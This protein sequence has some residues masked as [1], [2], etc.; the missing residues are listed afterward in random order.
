MTISLLTNK[1]CSLSLASGKV[2]FG[3]KKTFFEIKFV[4]VGGNLNC[5]SW[6]KSNLGNVTTE[7][8]VTF[9]GGKSFK[10]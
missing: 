3:R 7:T 9:N 1:K 8:I 4:R 5:E 2:T 6:R 10:N